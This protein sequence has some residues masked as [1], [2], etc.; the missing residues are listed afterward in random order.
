MSKRSPRQLA[1]RPM[2]TCSILQPRDKPQRKVSHAGVHG[3]AAKTTT[4]TRQRAVTSSSPRPPTNKSLHKT[5]ACG[6]I[7]STCPQMSTSLSTTVDK[8]A[9]NRHIYGSERR[10]RSACRTR[11]SAC[12]SQACRVRAHPCASKAPP[13]ARPPPMVLRTTFWRSHAVS[14]TT[15]SSEDP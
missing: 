10:R 9:E 1:E 15:A 13:R 11:A 14:W 7:F 3:L 4:E 5:T 8:Y 6:Q 12:C 2:W